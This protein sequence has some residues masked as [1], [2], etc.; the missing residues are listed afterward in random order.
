MQKTLATLTDFYVE[1]L[2]NCFNLVKKNNSIHYV[3]REGKV[4]FGTKVTDSV[5]DTLNF[6][7]LT[8]DD[9]TKGFQHAEEVFDFIIG[10]KYFNRH[11][12]DELELTSLDEE[13]QNEATKFHQYMHQIGAKSRY[14]FSLHDEV[15]LRAVDH[16]FPDARL[17]Q[18]VFGRFKAELIMIPQRMQA[19]RLW[20]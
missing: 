13:V 2:L 14:K 9:Y 11:F 12:F 7:D 18:E 20:R 16:A 10:S 4:S 19:G 8:M 1:A 6:L 17:K 3:F 5:R 15:Y